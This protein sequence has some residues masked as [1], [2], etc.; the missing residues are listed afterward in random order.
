MSP[1]SSQITGTHYV[2]ALPSYMPAC[3]RAVP[4]PHQLGWCRVRC[5]ILLAEMRL[6]CA[7]LASEVVGK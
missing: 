1:L 4:P 5:W 3:R 2:S 7:L 6:H